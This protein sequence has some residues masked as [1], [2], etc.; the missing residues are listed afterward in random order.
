MS[1]KHARWVGVR[2]LK[3][4]V[5]S[6]EAGVV[7]QLPVTNNTK[8]AKIK[9]CNQFYTQTMHLPCKANPLN[10]KKTRKFTQA[11]KLSR[12]LLPR[13]RAFVD[14][15]SSIGGWNSEIDPRDTGT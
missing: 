4:T 14:N 6:H 11:Q 9:G 15:F 12:F 13:I 5:L 10:T 3:N 7:I 1:G 2:D 8:L